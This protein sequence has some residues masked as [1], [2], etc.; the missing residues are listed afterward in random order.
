MNLDDIYLKEREPQGFVSEVSETIGDLGSV[1]KTGLDMAASGL[2]GVTQ[3]GVGLLGDLSLLSQMIAN[4]MGANFDEETFFY[5]TEEVKKMLDENKVPGISNFVDT[6]FKPINTP[7]SDFKPE[8]VEF[9]KRLYDTSEFTGEMISPAIELDLIAKGIKTAVKTAPKIKQKAGKFVE[10]L[11]ES[12]LRP[13]GSIQPGALIPQKTNVVPVEDGFF[14][15]ALMSLANIKQNKGT[16]EQFLQMLKNDPKVKPEE[17]QQLGLE[18]FLS[19][20][21]KFTK[22]EI[23]DY[24]KNNSAGLKKDVLVGKTKEGEN[25]QEVSFEDAE[26]E[27][28]SAM[29]FNKIEFDKPLFSSD[30]DFE[31][32]QMRERIYDDLKENVPYNALS[33]EESIINEIKFL[34]ERYGDKQDIKMDLDT[35][36]IPREF[37]SDLDIQDS[38]KELLDSFGVKFE[39]AYLSYDGQ[40]IEGTYE[41]YKPHITDVNKVLNNPDAK[42]QIALDKLTYYRDMYIEEIISGNSIQSLLENNLSEPR[43][44]Y[45]LSNPLG[46]KLDVEPSGGEEPFFVG[47]S[48][49][50]S[51]YSF[52]NIDDAMNQLINDEYHHNYRN[53]NT[54]PESVNTFKEYTFGNKMHGEKNVVAPN[55]KVF[56]FEFKNPE[57]Q[58][59]VI[60]K[61]RGTHF[62]GGELLHIR[63]SDRVAEEFPNDKSLYVEEIQSDYHK[64]GRGKK[65]IYSSQKEKLDAENEKLKNDVRELSE[66]LLKYSPETKDGYKGSKLPI[67]TGEQVD[68]ARLDMLQTINTFVNKDPFYEKQWNKLKSEKLSSTNAAGVIR[69]RDINDLSFEEIEIVL[70]Q[71]QKR[72]S[73]LINKSVKKASQPIPD[74]PFKEEMQMGVK[75]AIQIAIENNYDRI[76]FPKFEA[77]QVYTGSAPKER[78]REMQNFIK[79]YAKQYNIKPDVVT[80]KAGDKEEQFLS[81]KITDNFRN[82][83]KEEGQPLYSLAPIAAGSVA[84]SQGENDGN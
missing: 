6:S 61:T 41:F 19:S 76:I 39:E 2:K 80:V 37:I 81:Y 65:G 8:T 84:V 59:S 40:S 63:T 75:Q 77:V 53:S 50:Q 7:D 38:Y 46:Y 3:G 83:I 44:R 20:K 73:E 36:E 48:Y 29:Q 12:V 10:G 68:N 64:G 54:M 56:G 66:T 4:K 27:I 69:K 34:K 17:I 1:A 14:S 71:F 32:E 42:S 26:P 43:I 78:Y 70:K 28:I 57:L 31:M 82:K 21:D 47:N 45:T 5:T 23:Q 62:E 49:D 67:N 74:L 15:P 51:R 11:D 55:Y 16:G 9:L 22:T 25:V 79:K 35:V 24:I 13:T 18:E 58:Q 60:D 52:E 30:M 33:E 72:M